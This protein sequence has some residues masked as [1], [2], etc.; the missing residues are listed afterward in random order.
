MEEIPT[1][2]V[3]VSAQ[4][5]AAPAGTTVQVYQPAAGKVAAVLG[6]MVQDQLALLSAPGVPVELMVDL[7]VAV[8][9]A[10]AVAE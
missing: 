4:V 2:Q 10:V 3:E 9:M 7:P 8:P 1:V 5:E 6:F